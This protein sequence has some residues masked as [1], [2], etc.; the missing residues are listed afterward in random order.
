[1]DELS[2]SDRRNTGTRGDAFFA[3]STVAERAETYFGDKGKRGLLHCFHDIKKAA[4]AIRELNQDSMESASGDGPADGDDL[5][6]SG[7]A[8]AWW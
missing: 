2:D 6:D 5:A 8:S 3:A 1:M 4:G 7:W